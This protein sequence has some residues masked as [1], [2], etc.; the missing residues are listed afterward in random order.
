MYGR[1][2]GLSPRATEQW[3]Q[4][5]CDNRRLVEA[6]FR[7]YLDI[8]QDTYNP[9]GV[10]SP[11]ETHRPPHLFQRK[12]EGEGRPKT[13][14]RYCCLGQYRMA[15]WCKEEAYTKLQIL[16]VREVEKLAVLLVLNSKTLSASVLV[17]VICHQKGCHAACKRR[18]HDDSNLCGDI[19][20]RILAPES[21]RPDNVSETWAAPGQLPS[22]EQCVPLRAG[23][24]LTKRHQKDRIHGHFLGVTGVVRAG[25]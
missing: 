13:Y 6:R 9:T 24:R 16:L 15:N 14:D 19:I 5:A 18:S 1:A 22:S 10:R 21:Q 23:S 20:G 25:I 17:R 2:P 4:V 11:I 8:P 7:A 12:G 3:L